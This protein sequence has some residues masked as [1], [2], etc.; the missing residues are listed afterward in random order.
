[1]RAQTAPAGAPALDVDQVRADFP[2]FAGP[3]EGRRLVYLDSAA[4]TQK[5]RVVLDTVR[6]FYTSYNANVHRGVHR[7]S[8]RATEAYEG[9]R[10]KIA[11][12]IGAADPGEIVFVRG[13]TEAINLA[14]QSWARP[15][16]S[17]GDEIVLSAME[18]HSNIVPWQM[19][20][21]A[22]GARIRVAPMDDR[23]D[24]ILDELAKLLSARTRLVA[25]VQASN[26][27]GTVNPV[28]RIG[29][30]AHAVGALMLVDGAQAAAHL[31]V[32]VKELGCDFY[33]GSGHKM[34]APTGI[35]FLWA[36][37]ALLE[38]MPPWMGGGDMIRSVTFERTL[39]APPPAKFEAGTPNIAGAIGLGAATDYLEQLGLDRIERHEQD[40]LAY[41][42][43]T[44]TGVDGVRLI[45]TPH[46]RSGVLSFVVEGIH[47]HDVGT[48][49]DHDGIAVRTGHHCAQPVMDRFGVPATV[50][51]SVSVYNSRADL[52]ELADGLR[53]ARGLLL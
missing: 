31:P 48:V 7:L 9:A 33:A 36:R 34:F 21:E 44:L 8:V 24:L 47:P 40:L 27:L 25:V 43:D 6:D 46:H 19:I 1:M 15:R 52:D 14:A 13:A 53:R 22:T 50:R 39:Y 30:M 29:E 45:G 16:L 32:D 41:G 3:R 38:E 10:A 26:A 37:A 5:P 18:H 17:P 49:L 23:G 28:R 35:G 4:T 20:R 42:E 51:A 12:F 2:I 11:R